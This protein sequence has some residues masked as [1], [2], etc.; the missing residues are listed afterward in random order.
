MDTTRP[1]RV[2]GGTHT[3]TRTHARTPSGGGEGWR[4]LGFRC[5]QLVGRKTIETIDLPNLWKSRA[6]L[7]VR[8]AWN[9]PSFERRTRGGKKKKKRW[10]LNNKTRLFRLVACTL[11]PFSVFS[12][13]ERQKKKKAVTF[14]SISQSPFPLHVPY[15]SPPRMATFIRRA[16]FPVRRRYS[17][18]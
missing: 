2:I 6:R 5:F 9:Y 16:R 12:F 15:T 7:G 13:R 8:R 1:S 11:C 4:W 10:R 18:F 14:N 17:E 3:R